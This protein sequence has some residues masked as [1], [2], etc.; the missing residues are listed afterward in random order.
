MD[1][2]SAQE[3]TYIEPVPQQK[4]LLCEKTFREYQADQFIRVH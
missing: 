2:E 3:W 4:C 1:V